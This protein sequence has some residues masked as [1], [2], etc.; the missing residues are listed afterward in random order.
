M[1]VEKRKNGTFYLK[2]SVY[3]PKTKLPKN[4]SIYLGSNP[5]QAREKLKLLTD[6]S[7]I[8]EQIPDVQPYE[9]ELDVA[10]KALRKLHGFKTEGIK[11]LIEGYLNELVTAK[12]FVTAARDGVVVPTADCSGCRF[13]KANHCCH[14]NRN[15]M[16]SKY[17]DGRLLRCPACE[18]GQSEPAKG[19]IK[20]PRDFRER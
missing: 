2:K 18:L 11:K 17:R 16:H 7:V 10:V 5:V 4:T 9:M 3:N 12:Q 13:N 20:F 14:F 15:F 19:S 1:Y 6:D 8:W